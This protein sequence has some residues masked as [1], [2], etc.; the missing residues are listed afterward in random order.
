LASSPADLQAL[1]DAE[2]VRVAEAGQSFGQLAWRRF[3]RN[4]QAMVGLAVILLMAAGGIYA[5]LLA[6]HLPWYVEARRPDF[7]ENSFGLVWFDAYR[8]LDDLEAG[9]RDEFTPAFRHQ[10]AERLRMMDDLLQGEDST[11]FAEFASK[12]L[13]LIESADP[14]QIA[15]IRQLLQENEERFDSLSADLDFAPVASWPIVRNLV[16]L[17]VFFMVFY[18]IGL[19][20][21]VARRR[22]GGAGTA[23]GWTLG[24][25][26]LAALAW[27]LLLP[28]RFDAADYK[29]LE[30]RG[31]VERVVW[32][33]VPFG[34]NENILPDAKMPPAFLQVTPEEAAKNPGTIAPSRILPVWNEAK[35][36][37]PAT[38]RRHWLGTDASGR[39]LLTRLLYGARIA[40]SIG[41]VAVSIY[42]SIGVVVGA[43][44]GYCGGWIDLFVSRVIEIV[45]CFPSFFLILIIISFLGP[46]IFW[47]MIVIGVTGWTSEAR[48]TR[49]E[50]LRLSNLDFVSAVRASG[51]GDWR[52]VFLHILP[53]AIQPVLVSAS[54]G[55]ASAILIESALSYLGFGVQPPYASW[56]VLL[57][58]AQDDVRGMWW[59][60]VFPGAA[61][62]LTVTAFNLVGDASRDALDPRL[63]DKAG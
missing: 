53:N 9:R 61:I 15:A 36:G 55:I 14:P 22:L 24:L 37:R 3:R 30:K 46:N 60:T 35:D 47:V 7:Y 19:P 42:V 25:A 18:T 51:G 40:M 33:P 32:A 48:L 43:L 2:E 1:A 6:N 50:F 57:H 34:E 31:F 27:W 5:P 59:M 26:A 11:A 45:I 4:R 56:G 49:G 28:A 54:F 16:W 23:A 44:A 20:A 58:S 21:F 12:L 10:I 38:Y 62:F 52:I 8:K 63:V 13:P 29:Q 41:I 39:D 17:E